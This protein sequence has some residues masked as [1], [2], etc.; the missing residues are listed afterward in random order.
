MKTVD[1]YFATNSPWTYF[2]HDRFVTLV[3]EHGADV[4]L[5]PVDLGKVFPGSG[6]L[7]LAK[8]APQRQAYRLVELARW[9]D[10]LGVPINLQPKFATSGADLASR[11]ILAALEGGVA[12]GLAFA[13]AVMRARFAEDRDIADAATLAALADAQRQ[14]AA[15]LA[16]R[17]AAPDIAAR[18]DAQTQE[19]IDAAVFGAPWYVFEGLPYWGQDRLDFLA[20][21]LAK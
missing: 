13:G 17:A 10:A 18:Y 20:R 9:R 15:A 21:E 16:E 19:A 5:F 11:W 12:P 3:H 1:Y 14:D 2:G 6:G 4:N 8:R 7:P